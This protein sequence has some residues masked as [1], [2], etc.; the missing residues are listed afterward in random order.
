MLSARSAC[1]VVRLLY[2][3]DID[4]FSEETDSDTFRSESITMRVR[5]FITC[6]C[7]RSCGMW[8]TGIGFNTHFSIGDGG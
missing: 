4:S 8:Y 3:L 6:S 1:L 7:S 2:C 5:D